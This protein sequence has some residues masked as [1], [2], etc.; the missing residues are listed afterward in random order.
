[1][2]DRVGDAAA[3]GLLATRRL[4]PDARLCTRGALACEVPFGSGGGVVTPDGAALVRVVGG[5]S[6]V[7]AL[8]AAGGDSAIAFGRE[9][10]GPGEY[11][12]PVEIDRDAAGNVSVYDLFTRR[13]LRFAPDGR[14]VAN[15]VTQL[16]P[17]P[18]PVM[19]LVDGALLMVAA[20]DPNAKGDTLPLFV[21]A[22][23][24]DGAPQR[25]HALDLRLPSYGAGEF[26][27]MGR[28]FEALPQFAFGRDGRLVYAAGATAELAL[29]DST[30][31][32]AVRGGFRATGRRVT[33]ADIEAAVAA[34]IRRLP[35]MGPMRDQILE[36]MRHAAERHPGVTQLVVMADGEVWAREAPEA[37]T[38]SVAWLVYSASLGPQARVRMSVDDRPVGVHAGRVLLA[39][40]GEDEQS[41]G[42]WWMRAAP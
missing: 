3:H 23:A 42:Y 13:L 6:S 25:R 40:S 27:A 22:V 10:A 11:R 31:R 14:P 28:T 24:D 21:Y 2:T 5:R 29:F 39:R 12:A 9:G 8:V 35:S 7:V 1:M 37:G 20:E 17:A 15:A 34:Q 32:L 33:E 19:R 30:G 41:S 4:L 26:V 16:P 38:D 18:Q 36:R